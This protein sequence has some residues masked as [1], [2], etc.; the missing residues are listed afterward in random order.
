[1]PLAPPASIGIGL[2]EV[3]WDANG[4]P[5]IRINKQLYRPAEVNSVRGD[6]S[7]A[8][9]QLGWT[10]EVSFAQLVEMMV[11][12]DLEQ[13]SG[14]NAASTPAFSPVPPPRH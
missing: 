7:K 1:M 11:K 9:Q 3:G 2:D 10:P 6:Y 12:T 13:L 14:R 8:R 5:I 4:R